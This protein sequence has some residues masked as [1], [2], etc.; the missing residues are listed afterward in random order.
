MIGPACALLP[1]DL[2]RVTVQLPVYNERDVVERLVD[3]AAALDWPADR[4]EIQLLDDS[5]DDTA[6]RAGPALARARAR[7]LSVSVLRRADRSGFKAGAL[8]AG[9]T[10]AQSDVLAI[11]DADFVPDPAFL[12]RTV[13]HLLQ[14]G[15]GM[16]QCRWGHLNADS[17]AL[18][19]AEAGLLDGHFVVE[20]VARNRSG[21]W[22][23]FNGTA[24]IWRRA[25]IEAGG[26][27][28]HDTLTEDLDLSYRAQLAGWRFVYLVDD[29]VPAELPDSMAAFR[30]QQRRW[31]K[32]SIETLRKLGGR[33]LRAPVPLRVKAE[34]LS[35][36]GANL[37]W[38][39][40]VVLSVLLPLVVV[41]RGTA[42]TG[43]LWL[44]LPAFGFSIGVNSLYY[45]AAGGWRWRRIP[46]VLALGIGMAV[47]QS[48]ATFDGLRGAPSA[49]V[50]T[51]KNG[52]GTGSYEPVAELPR[53][54][55][56]VGTF[57]VEAGLSLLSFSAAAVAASRGQ[58]GSLPFLFLFGTGYA[59]VALAG[60]GER[61]AASVA[62]R[63]AA[64]RFEPAPGK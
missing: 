52:G 30:A 46:L 29:A 23:N 11:F 31:A 24:G 27:W 15:V 42:S 41:G 43:H 60:L 6:Q 58:L 19:Q 12:R 32:G 18:T 21:A 17:G 1:A 34:A 2:P 54:D 7:G 14:D 57:P 55:V 51:P 64:E 8:A 28:Q 39:L 44:D 56:R 5:T 50:R 53:S 62:R 10:R 33:I 13:P 20:Q 49:F 59:W 16:V 25:A 48:L 3:A 61:Q 45:A 40:V 38:P 36:L 26:G 37:A 4:L 35:H 22:F 47:A 63:A 9:L